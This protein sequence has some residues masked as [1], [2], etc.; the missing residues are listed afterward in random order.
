MW[1]GI[2]IS[3]IGPSALVSIFVLAIL[4]RKLVPS[5]TYKEKCQESERWRLAYEAERTGRI[6]SDKQTSELLELA[7]TT[8][9][10]VAAIYRIADEMRDT[11]DDR[12][13][14]RRSRWGSEGSLSQRKSRKK[15]LTPLLEAW[16]ESENAP[17]RSEE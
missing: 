5:P 16:I 12:G 2:P 14:T 8:H 10:Y 11:G 1:E 4:L 7:K 3:A 9:N 6:L 17:P 13:R 15:L